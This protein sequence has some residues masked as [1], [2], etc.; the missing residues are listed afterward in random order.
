MATA[1]SIR[2]AMSEATATMD[3]EVPETT[4]FPAVTAQS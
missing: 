4:E 1:K 2:V 3:R